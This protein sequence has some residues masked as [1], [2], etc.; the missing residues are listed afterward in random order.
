[1]V[2]S[3]P[4]MG[5]GRRRPCLKQGCTGRLGKQEEIEVHLQRI[6]LEIKGESWTGDIY[7]G[8]TLFDNR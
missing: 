3:L 6:N 4:E 2:V 7:L 5:E 8:Y 1:M